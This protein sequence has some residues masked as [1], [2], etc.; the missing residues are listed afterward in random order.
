MVWAGRS[1]IEIAEAV[2]QG[3]ATAAAIADGLLRA[4]GA[5]GER[6][7]DEA[8]AVQKRA[9]LDELPLAGVPVAVS[10]A[11]ERPAHA[12]LRA[13]GALLVETG[14]PCAE[15]VAAGLVPLA[16]G[17]D[18]FG[19]L[20]IRAACHGVLAL[21]PGRGVIPEATGEWREWAPLARTAEDLA[22]VLSVLAGEP[23]LASAW[24]DPGPAGQWGL[25]DFEDDDWLLRPPRGVPPRRSGLRVAAAPQPL[26]RGLGVRAGFGAAVVAAAER[27][28]EAGHTVVDHPARLPSSLVLA[29]IAGGRSPGRAPE[30]DGRPGRRRRER[31]R[32]YGADQWF[33]DADV[34]IVPA[35]AALPLPEGRTRLRDIAVAAPWNLSGWPAL[36]LPF[37]ARPGGVQ[38]VAPPGSEPHLLL[39]AAQLA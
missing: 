12:R 18:E 29:T 8:R 7:A 14:R 34:L 11:G 27:L 17:S 37:G 36:S 26:P 23:E 20:R 1:A 31:W 9:D 38:L 28:R 16:L 4:V 3:E 2:R 35:L 33:G 5:D 30:R 6:L 13:A 10:S 32:D 25:P 24:R 39:L 19:S 21:K 15:D 22:L